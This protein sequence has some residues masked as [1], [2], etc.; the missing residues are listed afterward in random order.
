MKLSQ[1]T[2]GSRARILDVNAPIFLRRR[3][4]ELGCAPNAIIEVLSQQRKTMG[5]IYAVAGVVLG[6]KKNIAQLILVEKL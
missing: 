5:G 1:L 3:I 2:N 6:I 4:F